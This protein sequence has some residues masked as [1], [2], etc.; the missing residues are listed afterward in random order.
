MTLED[1]AQYEVK[2]DYALE[3]T[4]RG[5]K[6]Y[7]T[8]APTSGPVLLHMFNLLEQYE[9]FVSEG[10]TGLNVHRLLEIM[11]CE[12]LSLLFCL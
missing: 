8:Q 11:K 4:Y 6:I 1:L 10:R 3:G 9:D 5:R 7:T 12:S 2:L